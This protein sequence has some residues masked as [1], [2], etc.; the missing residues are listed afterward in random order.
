MIV[1]PHLKVALTA[2]IFVAFFF[3]S[4]FAQIVDFDVSHIKLEVIPDNN[5]LRFPEPVFGLVR[6]TNTSDKEEFFP[7]GLFQIYG[8]TIDGANVQLGSVLLQSPELTKVSAGYSETVAFHYSIGDKKQIRAILVDKSP[9]TFTFRTYGKPQN[10]PIENLRRLDRI[11]YDEAGEFE[12]LD[13]TPVTVHY[14]LENLIFQ[15]PIKDGF[16][17]SLNENFAAKALDPTRWPKISPHTL[18]Q[19]ISQSPDKYLESSYFLAV[20]DNYLFDHVPVVRLFPKQTRTL[21]NVVRCDTATWRFLDMERIRQFTISRPESPEARLRAYEDYIKVLKC[22]GRGE[23]YYHFSSAPNPGYYRKYEIVIDGKTR[24]LDEYLA[25]RTFIDEV[26]G[27]YVRVDNPDFKETGSDSLGNDEHS[28]VRRY[29]W[30]SLI[31]DTTLPSPREA[32]IKR[33]IDGGKQGPNPCPCWNEEED[34]KVKIPVPFPVP[35][36]VPAESEKD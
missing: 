34:A 35:V 20:G 11:D 5:V 19:P 32:S 6:I 10:L 30:K 23:A 18:K 4:L 3:R 33:W 8:R 15:N 13:S 9:L 16:S 1:L 29:I 26:P 28:R 21:Q 12:H 7:A 31:N 17:K 25:E 2:C 36:P 24:N 14:S 27:L 22:M